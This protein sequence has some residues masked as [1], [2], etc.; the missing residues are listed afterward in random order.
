MLGLVPSSPVPVDCSWW[1]LLHLLSLC[2]LHVDSH[3]V[4]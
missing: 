4:N 2:I 1:P 3:L